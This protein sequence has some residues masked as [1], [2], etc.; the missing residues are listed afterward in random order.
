MKKERLV[1]RCWGIRKQ[2]FS[3]LCFFL[4]NLKIRI[5]S[6]K[7]SLFFFF[8]S[9]WPQLKTVIALLIH[10]QETNKKKRTAQQA[11]CYDSKDKKLA[12]TNFHY[13]TD[14]F[15]H[16]YVLVVGNIEI[17]IEFLYHE[18]EKTN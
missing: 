1:I 15:N 2:H 9:P 13:N 7:S 12:I 4:Y 14:K 5:D 18:K 3:S 6:T 10:F 8:F 16:L 11:G 17:R